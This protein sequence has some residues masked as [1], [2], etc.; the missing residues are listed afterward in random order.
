VSEEHFNHA[1]LLMNGDD[2][3]FMIVKENDGNPVAKILF[4]G[5]T[6]KVICVIIFFITYHNNFLH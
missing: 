4:F 1:K 5:R 3:Y 2:L 6:K